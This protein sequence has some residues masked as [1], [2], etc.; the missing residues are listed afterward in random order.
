MDISSC[1]LINKKNRLCM[2]YGNNFKML[3]FTRAKISIKDSDKLR[4]A[5]NED[6]NK[7]KIIKKKVDNIRV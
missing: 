3:M 5:E 7:L 6:G 1:L 4:S 2:Y